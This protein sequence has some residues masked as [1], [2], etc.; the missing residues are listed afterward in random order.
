MRWNVRIFI[1][2]LHVADKNSGFWGTK[3]TETD[4]DLVEV[5]AN[6][7]RSLINMR[8]GSSENK[9][10]L[11]EED[12]DTAGMLKKKKA[13]HQGLEEVRKDMLGY[14]PKFIDVKNGRRCYS[15]W[16]KRKRKYAYGYVKDAMRYYDSNELHG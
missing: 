12:W 7:L 16:C 14:W 1:H 9:T 10:K 8:T 4:M 3:D 11:K 6:V 5:K 2:F 13:I 15:S